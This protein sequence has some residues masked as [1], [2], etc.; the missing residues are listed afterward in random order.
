MGTLRRECLDHLL[1]HGGRHLRKVLTKYEH[2]FNHHRP[3]QGRS[4]RL[5]LHNP[6]Q[7]IDMTLPDP[8]PKDRHRTDQ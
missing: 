8:P 5:P 4:L 3:H 2:H 6:S 1:I 7:M